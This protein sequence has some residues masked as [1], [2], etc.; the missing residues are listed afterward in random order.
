[1]LQDARLEGS[2]RAEGKQGAEETVQGMEERSEKCSGGEMMGAEILSLPGKPTLRKDEVA[3]I[4]DCSV[5]H[6]EHLMEEGSLRGTDIKSALCRRPA[7]RIYTE[8][9]REFAEK[10][11]L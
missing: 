6:V 5:R 3:K 4:F 11:R 2:L 7:I 9:V 1:M 8:S 10:R